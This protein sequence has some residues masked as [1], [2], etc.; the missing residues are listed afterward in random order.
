MFNRVFHKLG[1]VAF[2]A[3]QHHT[4]KQNLI[5]TSVQVPMHTMTTK[6]TS[7]FSSQS[8]LCQQM[9]LVW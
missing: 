7:S 5:K 9:Y 1:K 8:I 4:N 3:S 6:L 2:K